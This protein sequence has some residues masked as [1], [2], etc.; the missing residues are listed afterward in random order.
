MPGTVVRTLLVLTVAL[1]RVPRVVAFLTNHPT[2]PKRVFTTLVHYKNTVDTGCKFESCYTLSQEG[3]VV[4][5]NRV[6]ILINEWAR[7]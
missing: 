2:L 3:P 6:I 1:L 7:F 4:G 5:L